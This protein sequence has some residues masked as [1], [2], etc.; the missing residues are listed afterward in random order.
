MNRT[1]WSRARAADR[2]SKSK[3]RAYDE[4]NAIAAGIILSSPERHTAFQIQWAEAFTKRKA[5]ESTA[6]LSPTE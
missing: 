2:P 4:Q 1:K 6:A 3:T 5:A